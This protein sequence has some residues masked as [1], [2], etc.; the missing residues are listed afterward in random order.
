MAGSLAFQTDV[1]IANRA[2][3]HLRKRRIGAFSDSSQQA[4]ELGFIFDKVREAELRNNL[5]RFATRRTVM[6][7]ISTVSGRSVMVSVIL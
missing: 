4:Q 1:D 6:W 7:P 5:W 2:L 3:Q